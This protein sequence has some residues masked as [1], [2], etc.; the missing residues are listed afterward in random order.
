MIRRILNLIAPD[1]IYCIS[2]GCFIDE[3]RAYSLCNSCMEH[4]HWNTGR[5]C[6]ICGKALYDTYSGDICYD[7]TENRHLFDRGFSCVDYGLLERTMIMNFKYGGRTYMGRKMAEMMADRISG[8]DE[9]FD[10]IVPVPIHRKRR[11]ERGFNQA[12]ILASGLAGRIGVRYNDRILVRTRETAAMKSL[13]AVERREN[14]RGVFC[15]P[16][17]YRGSAEG[18]NILLVDDIY[19]TGATADACSQVLKEAGASKCFIYS[20][21]SAPNKRIEYEG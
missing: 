12:E 11:D 18:R 3:S 4:I 8:T 13:S 21:A 10:L 7:C 5:T 2:C 17:R 9:Q 20:F 14:L 16:E 6:S 1:N 19:T 15:V